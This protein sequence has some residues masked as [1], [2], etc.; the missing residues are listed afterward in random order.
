MARPRNEVKK[1]GQ[2]ARRALYP[3]PEDLFKAVEEYFK[4]CEANYEFPDYA[5]MLVD[6]QLFEEDVEYYKSLDEKYVDV[7][8]LAML[9]RQSYLSRTMSNDGKRATGCMNLL[10][11]P[12]NGGYSDKPQVKDKSLKIE[13][14]GVKGGM[15]AFK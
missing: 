5:G 11:Q 7:F 2:I 9:K 14:S 4:K 12:E 3:E 15:N 6:L 13:V 10:K 1:A 8:R